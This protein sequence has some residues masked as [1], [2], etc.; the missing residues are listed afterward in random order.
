M[1]PYFAAQLEKLGFIGPVLLGVGFLALIALFWLVWK[2]WIKPMIDRYHQSLMAVSLRVQRSLFLDSLHDEKILL[3]LDAA[4][5]AGI[6]HPIGDQGGEI[7]GLDKEI[8]SWITGDS[9][10]RVLASVTNFYQKQVSYNLKQIAEFYVDVCDVSYGDKF[11]RGF[12]ERYKELTSQLRIQ[13]R[14][15]RA[16]KRKKDEEARIKQG[17]ELCRRPAANSQG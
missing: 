7:T 8:M 16:A 3:V 13:I 1:S 6:L 11:L 14:N 5:N 2:I 4:R 12:E 9:L 10:G 15:I 17:L